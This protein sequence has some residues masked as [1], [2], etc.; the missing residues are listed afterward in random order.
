VN[1]HQRRVK[2]RK[3]WRDL[4]PLTAEIERRK[5]NLYA[6]LPGFAPDAPA[7]QPT[8]IF[9]HPQDFEEVLKWAKEEK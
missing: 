1:S 9:M 7:L 2:K 8:K 3:L 6:A 4:K 5:A